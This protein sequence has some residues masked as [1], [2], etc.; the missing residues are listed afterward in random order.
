MEKTAQNILFTVDEINDV[1]KQLV[2]HANGRKVWL[3][4]GEMG[5]G[6]TTLIQ[7][8]CEGLGVD[9]QATSPTYSIINEYNA[10][11][12][13]APIY[14]MDLYRLKNEE[15]ALQI[16]IEEY[17]YGGV[18]CFIEWPD[19]ILNLLPEDCFEI[20][21]SIVGDSKRKIIFVL[22]EI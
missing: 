3:F 14:H 10:T 11:S 7:A 20:Q 18:Y 1:A 8:I 13:D 15:E 12:I 19:I 22:P 5:A 16:G 17:L 21:L 4:R 9:E 2:Q 6:K